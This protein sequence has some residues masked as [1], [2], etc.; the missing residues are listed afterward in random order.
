MNV[1]HRKGGVEMNSGCRKVFMSAVV[2]VLTMVATTCFARIPLREVNLGGV[3]YGQ[4]WE[5]VINTLGSPETPGNKRNVYLFKSSPTTFFE[6][7]RG[8]NGTAIGAST[9]FSG[10][11]YT[12]KGIRP[13]YSSEEAVIEAYGQPDYVQK[14]YG[15]HTLEYISDT[16]TCVLK[17]GITASLYNRSRQ[18]VEWILFCPYGKANAGD[19]GKKTQ[20]TPSSPRS[21]EP[22]KPKSTIPDFVKEIPKTELNIGWIEPGQTMSHV[23][24]VYGK[25]SK[26]DDQGFFQIYS[27]NDKFVVKGKMNNGYRVTSVA[28]Y[29][30]GM[31]TPSGFMV[32]DSYADI[33]KKIGTVK[34]NKFKGEG[35]EAKLKGCTEYTYYCNDKQ[36]VFIVD[37]NDVIRA[38]RV[39]ELDEQ[40]FIEAKRKK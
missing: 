8:T 39:E 29:E 21:Q 16:G 28:S 3:Y 17:F 38:I 18:E 34:G 4:P 11:A 33:T 23:E 20:P 1:K 24:E 6:V 40:K 37:K 2:T 30:K 31:K 12:S 14:G 10:T 7:T 22:E 35:I 32:G 36:M 13:N 25:P 5:E 27:Y 9:G 15:R 19:S 26:I